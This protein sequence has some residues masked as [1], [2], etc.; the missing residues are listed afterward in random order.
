MKAKYVIDL[1][2]ILEFL[3]DKKV[4]LFQELRQI[5]GNYKATYKIIEELEEKGEVRMVRTA[6]GRHIVI[7]HKSIK[8]WF[9]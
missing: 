1:Q 8:E 3:E 5:I 7:L 2:K 9:K 6:G 4:V